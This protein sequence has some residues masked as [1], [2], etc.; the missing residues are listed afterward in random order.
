MCV[1]SVGQIYVS[2]VY[3]TTLHIIYVFIYL[4]SDVVKTTSLTESGAQQLTSL[5]V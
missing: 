3:P 4:F 2:V 1:V 5:S